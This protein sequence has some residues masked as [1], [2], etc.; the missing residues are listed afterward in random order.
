MEVAMKCIQHERTK[1]I[2]RVDNER[3]MEMVQGGAWHYTSKF[4]WK[5]LVRDA[6][7]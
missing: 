1:E 2:K 7:A 6:K 4:K 5:R 3:A